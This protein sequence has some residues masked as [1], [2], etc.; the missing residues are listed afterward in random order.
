MMTINNG[1]I[2]VQGNIMFSINYIQKLRE[3]HIFVAQCQDLAMADPKKGRS[4]P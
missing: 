4:D 3:F 1:D 2:E